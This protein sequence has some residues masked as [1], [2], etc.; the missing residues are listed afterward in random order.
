MSRRSSI[1]HA[2]VLAAA[3]AAA[4]CTTES[5]RGLHAVPPASN[6]AEPTIAAPTDPIPLTSP[7][8]LRLDTVPQPTT[9]RTTTTALPVFTL[10]SVTEPPFRQPSGGSGQAPAG[11]AGGGPVIPASV[12]VSAVKASCQAPN[13]NQADGTVISFAPQNVV[14]GNPLTAWRCASPV[15]GQ[16]LT[17]RLPGATRLARVGLINGYTK[18][19]PSSGVD[20]Y[21][22]NHRIKKVRW[23]F[24][25]GHSIIQT[26]RDGVREVQLIDVNVRTKRVTLT[27]LADYDSSF[28]RT[29]NRRRDFLPISEISLIGG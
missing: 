27:I 24:D 23:D 13:G 2:T 12:A 10:P 19:D 21:V 4:G 28:G 14:D 8:D 6:P 1:A 9:P 16:Q 7:R 11:A 25:G 3:L 15:N 22:E 20:R 29:S 17:V 26:L 5:S 18:T